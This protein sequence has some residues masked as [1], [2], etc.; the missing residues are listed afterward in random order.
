MT[1]FARSIQDLADRINLIITLYF[2]LLGVCVVLVIIA[3]NKINS[4]K[5][6][7][8]GVMRESTELRHELSLMKQSMRNS[9]TRQ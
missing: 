2:I 6:N 4:L 8:Q 9:G 3:I 5:E 1:D 7:M